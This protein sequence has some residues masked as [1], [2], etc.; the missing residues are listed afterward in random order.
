MAKDAP[1][2]TTTVNRAWHEA[3]RLAHGSSLEDRVRW[4]L[5]HAKS[6]ACR[7]IPSSVRAELKR[8]VAEG[9]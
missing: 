9:G 8:R 4:H 7:P 2:R 6:C 3:H 1:A 5:A